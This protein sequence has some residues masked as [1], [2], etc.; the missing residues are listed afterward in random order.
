MTAGRFFM[1]WERLYRGATYTPE[2]AGQPRLYVPIFSSIDAVTRSSALTEKR[3]L[4]APELAEPGTS[5]T[6]QKAEN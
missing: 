4:V 1:L 5:K 2:L 6:T 3:P